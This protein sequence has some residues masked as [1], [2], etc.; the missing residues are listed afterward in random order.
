[1]NFWLLRDSNVFQVHRPRGSEP[2]ESCRDMNHDV[3][4]DITL[5]GLNVLVDGMDE[6]AMVTFERGSSACTAA[7]SFRVRKCLVKSR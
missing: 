7:C 3:T 5:P 1:M 4:M 6:S 2:W